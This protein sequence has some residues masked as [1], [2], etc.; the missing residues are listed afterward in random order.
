MTD[1]D[2]LIARAQ[3]GLAFLFALAFIV[4]LLVLLVSLTGVKELPAAINAL[5]TGL[6]GVFGT[7]LTLQQNYFF[8][9]QRPPTVPDPVD[10]PSSPPATD[11]SP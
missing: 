3:V 6:L 9:R 10:R 7:I 8:A 4:V 11:P 5:L 2:K 1:T